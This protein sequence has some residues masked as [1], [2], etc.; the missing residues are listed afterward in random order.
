M[1]QTWGE[2]LDRLPWSTVKCFVGGMASWEVSLNGELS[3]AQSPDQ[4]NAP[5]GFRRGDETLAIRNVGR[6]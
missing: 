6:H 4:T 5:L 2:L 1:C 3:P